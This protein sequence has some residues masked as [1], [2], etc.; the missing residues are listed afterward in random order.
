MQ[1]AKKATQTKCQRNR[2]VS[3]RFQ[4]STLCKKTHD[5]TGRHNYAK[6]HITVFYA[7]EIHNP[8]IFQSDNLQM[9]FSPPLV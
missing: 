8:H 5:V 2:Q 9:H 1:T 3:R 7:K 4:G 6:S